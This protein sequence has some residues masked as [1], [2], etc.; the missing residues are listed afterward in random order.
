MRLDVSSEERLFAE[1]VRSAI[2][3]WE[4]TREPELAAWLDDRDDAL[5]ARLAHA[6]WTELWADPGLL[7]AAVA[8]AVELGRATAPACVLDET[9]LGGALAVGGR[10]RHGVGASRLAVP[11]LSGGLASADVPSALARES[12]LDGSGTVRLTAGALD[13]LS[14]PEARARWRAWTAV[15]LAYL[16]GLAADALDRSVEHARRRE[17]FGAPLA[18][19][20]AVRGRHADAAL[21]VDALALVARASADG[22]G[23][24]DG[25]ALLW[26]GGACC[27]VTAAAH[28]VHGALGFALQTGLHR[29]HRR[30]TATQ[31]WAAA[32]C[33]ATR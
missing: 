11:L 26:A 9:T 4:P 23:G 25:P 21:A 12:T 20:P 28:Q 33:A 6:G 1:S 7:G 30:A 31:A 24:V 32:V 3:G 17:Q 19:L 27:E 2:G 14:A 29:L 16:A 8:G 18:A 22:D 5:A 10:A 15:T 13:E